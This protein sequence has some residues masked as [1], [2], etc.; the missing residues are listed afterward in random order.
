MPFT[1][2]PVT[3]GQMNSDFVIF[4]DE[5]NERE[6]RDTTF[7]GGKGANLGEMYRAHLP[8]PDA[9]VVTT[10]AH[11]TFVK[12]HGIDRKIEQMLPRINVDQINSWVKNDR[13]CPVI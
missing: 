2:I 3:K 10:K 6:M 7:A 12:S 1:T 11:E 4:L 9:F 8:V 13:L 5:I